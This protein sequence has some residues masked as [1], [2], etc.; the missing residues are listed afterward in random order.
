MYNYYVIEI[1]THSDGTSGNLVTGFEDKDTSEDAY[2]AARAS[3]ND[4]PIHCHTVMWINK[5]G[6]Y[7]EEPKC[8]HHNEPL[9]EEPEGEPSE[10]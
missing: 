9:P 4:S 5:E 6:K 10:P 3:A 1:Q 8:Y 7:M 2:M